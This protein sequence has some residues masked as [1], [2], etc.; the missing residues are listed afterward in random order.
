[1]RIWAIADLH[2]SFG[3]PN[4]G[5]DIFG[6]SW[7]RHAE[8]V[9]EYWHELVRAEDLVL[10]PGDISWATHMDQALVDLEWIDQLPGQKVMIR[11][12]HDYWWS[13][14]T[15]VRK[16]LPPSLSIIQNNALL[17]NGTAIGGARLWDCPEVMFP[18]EIISTE[19]PT[20]SSTPRKSDEALKE[21]EKIYKR[22]LNRL[23]L[24]LKALD[25]SAKRRIVMTHY[26]PVNSRMGPS[27]AR[28]LLEQYNVDTCVF[29]HLHNVR[30][31][32]PLFGEKNGVRYLLA[33]CDYLHCKP[34]LVVVH[35][36]LLN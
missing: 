21:A 17:W 19:T 5:M 11:G 12:N 14:P 13:S 23:E 28:D 22:E 4:K 31:D 1:M 7:E 20:I 16:A 26:P 15:K 18:E 10:L 36:M 3:I 29:G 33:S 24:S 8:R 25:K 30:G 32:L 34:L 9:A 27:R 6:P 35:P 2:L